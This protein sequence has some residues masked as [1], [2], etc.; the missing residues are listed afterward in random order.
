ME[1]TE[2]VSSCT[3]CVVSYLYPDI[4]IIY[5]FT[6][7]IPDPAYSSDFEFGDS[8]YELMK[9][10][11]STIFRNRKCMAEGGALVEIENQQENEYLKMSIYYNNWHHYTISM[12]E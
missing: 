1:K 11:T 9:K 2:T 4:I 6:N 3:Q 12:G 7:F 10:G 8:T 5:I